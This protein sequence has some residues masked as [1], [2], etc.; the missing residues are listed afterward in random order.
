MFLNR[1]NESICPPGRTV[2]K[3]L[4]PWLAYRSVPTTRTPCPAISLYLAGDAQL[5][6]RNLCGS[7][8]NGASGFSLIVAVGKEPD[9]DL[10]AGSLHGRAHRQVASLPHDHQQPEVNYLPRFCPLLI[11]LERSPPRGDRSREIHL[12]ENLD[13]VHIRLLVGLIPRWTFS[14]C[15]NPARVGYRH[16][17]HHPWS[18][19]QELAQ[20]DPY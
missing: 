8:A 5:D 11:C 15:A 1:I 7:G 17:R 12:I 19:G 16:L 2:P 6:L 9:V 20:G 4:L 13:I 14:S 3:K 18:A 10:V